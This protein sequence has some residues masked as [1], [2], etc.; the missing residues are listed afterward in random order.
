M[1]TPKIVFGVKIILDDADNQVSGYEPIGL[2]NKDSLLTADIAVLDNTATV[3]DASVFNVGDLIHVSD[4][5]NGESNRIVG[6]IANVLYMSKLFTNAYTVA[7]SGKVV[8][9]SELRWIQNE[10]TGLS[11]WCDSMLVKK[12]IGRWSRSIDLRRGGNTSKP[13]SASVKIR[14]TEKFYLELDDRGINLAGQRILIVE[15]QDTTLINRWSGILNKPTWSTTTYSITAK[16]NR[17]K[18]DSNLTTKTTPATHPNA[19]S[20]ILNKTTPVTFGII[21]PLL[22]SEDNVLHNGYA[23][24]VRTAN[25]E[26]LQKNVSDLVI[27]DDGDRML[28]SNAKDIGLYSYPSIYPRTGGWY[29][30]RFKLGSNIG[31]TSFSLVDNAGTPLP[32]A[33]YDFNVWNG[34][35]IKVV[36]GEQE[37]VYRQIAGGEC[38]PLGMSGDG[39][40][41]V[42]TLFL[43]SYFE[44][45]LS[46]HAEAKGIDQS[47]ISVYDIDSEYTLDIQPCKNFLDEDGNVSLDNDLSLYSYFN[48][49]SI[50]S[51]THTTEDTGTFTSETVSSQ[52]EEPISFYLLP[53]FAYKIKS[54]YSNNSVELSIE[55]F[56]ESPNNLDSFTMLPPVSIEP[57]TEDSLDSLIAEDQDSESGSPSLYNMEKVEYKTVGGDVPG[58]YQRKSGGYIE[59]DSGNSVV[60]GGLAELTDKNRATSY[61]H[62]LEF[63][64]KT[65]GGSQIFC[66]IVHKI[67]LPKIPRKYMFDNVYMGA[68]VNT[69]ATNVSGVCG[70][71]VFDIRTRRFIG[72]AGSV[73]N[74]AWVDDKSG[75][76][77]QI[78]SDPDFYYASDNTDTKDKYF[79]VKTDL[80]T[81]GD[82][83]NVSGYK[84]F[85]LSVK[86]HDQYHTYIDGCLVSYHLYDIVAG[87]QTIDFKIFQLMIILHKKISIKNE[88][89]TAAQGRIF[90]DSWN[91]RKT[92]ADLMQSPIDIVEHVERLSNWS[93]RS[94][95]PN[96]DWGK[97]YAEG[98]QVKRGATGRGSYDD[99]TDV[100]IQRIRNYKTSGQILKHNEA[101]SA[102]VKKS[103]CRDFWLANWYDTDGNSN[104]AT[105]GKPVAGE[106]YPPISTI[107]TLSDIIDRSKIKITEPNI[108]DMFPEPYV[109]FNKNFA[110]GN[111]EG[112]VAVTNT[113]KDTYQ[114]GY[115]EG[116]EGSSASAEDL[117][118]RCHII[119]L[120]CG[121]LN[122]PPLD[123]TDKTWLND[124]VSQQIAEDYL[125]KWADWMGNG[126]ISF[127]VHHLTAANW[128]ESKEII[129]KLPHQTNNV[130]VKVIITNIVYDPNSYIVDVEGIY[131]SETLPE[132]MVIKDTW[133]TLSPIDDW[134]DSITVY[135]DDNDIKD[136][137]N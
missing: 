30:Y 52:K 108:R 32:N 83:K 39:D 66:S 114:S 88:V 67:V 20:D 13:G 54:S 72:W 26:T 49:S 101:S 136:M 85:D 31:N 84:N 45:D 33:T 35:Y 73:L 5:S 135:G 65:A 113:D 15:F 120:K 134:K 122:K 36:E 68:M 121:H 59:V 93:D 107:I 77:A 126:T 22:D 110:N 16:S 78:R 11:G 117:W 74:K 104:I 9:N 37:G 105:F 97:E 55:L 42:I 87:T 112:R 99:I 53:S 17:N 131:L 119:W 2:Y 75:T 130:E 14:N 102:K 25:K 57:F 89:Y 10:I 4:S 62:E 76:P 43:K 118:D 128:N 82:M 29:F 1:A 19:T 3:A 48:D 100:R 50:N 98:A 79:W 41:S 18:R 124:N 51:K 90:N 27:N 96:G 38:H 8:G 91:G 116:W 123:M 6:V 56:K 94:L 132:D 95:P 12:G 111:H 115:I 64:P 81:S 44:N 106:T 80:G 109:N 69:E 46:G 133:A 71:S 40:A 61:Y 34:M 24:M 86:N 103:L 28:I 63:S 137:S 23:K 58:V 70:G 47:W 125:K 7:N 129:I 21:K 127:N 92:A 60:S